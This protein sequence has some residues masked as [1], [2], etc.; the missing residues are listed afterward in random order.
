MWELLNRLFF[1]TYDP[2]VLALQ[3]GTGAGDGP[4]GAGAAEWGTA[5]GAV[6][7]GTWAVSAG[8]R[9]AA[10]QCGAGADALASQRALRRR[11]MK[12]GG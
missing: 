2:T 7:G 12:K 3:R 6:Q 8:R 5:R 4:T 10:C 1:L 11:E 9:R